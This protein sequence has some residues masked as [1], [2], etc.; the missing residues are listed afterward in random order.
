MN[1][2]RVESLSRTGASFLRPFWNRTV[3]APWL[4]SLLVLLILAAARFY[5]TLGPPAAR[6]LFLLQCLAMWAVPFLF[7]T[8]QGRCEIG[9]RTQG[10][11]AAAIAWSALAGAGSALAVFALGM[12]LYGES[13]DN[14]CVSIRD[15]FQLNQLRGSMPIAELFAMIALPA[16][17]LTP[18]GEEILFRGFIQQA[19]SRR[20]NATVATVVNGLGFGLIHLHVHGIWRD[21]A[22]FHVHVVSGALMVVLMAATSYVFTQCRQRSGSLWTAMVAHSICNL[23]MIATIFFHYLN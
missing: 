3:R 21:G 19:F 20:W 17:I 11:S 16:M 14:W 9:L 10:N 15:S 23:V 22:G 2:Q 8:R 6:P 7:L 4:L 18:V 1:D 5:A 13:P 12:A